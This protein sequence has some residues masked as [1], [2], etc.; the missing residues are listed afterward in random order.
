MPICAGHSGQSRSQD[1][2][3]L[4][5]RSLRRSPFL[6]PM[7]L[8]DQAQQPQPPPSPPSP[9]ASKPARSIGMGSKD[10]DG[11]LGV[12]WVPDERD[13]TMTLA[14]SQMSRLLPLSILGRP[15]DWLG[16]G[17]SLFHGL[18]WIDR[19][20]AWFFDWVLGYS[21]SGGTALKIFGGLSAVNSCKDCRNSESGELHL[22]DRFWF[23]IEETLRFVQNVCC[24]GAIL[25]GVVN[26]LVMASNH[27]GIGFT[28]VDTDKLKIELG[29]MSGMVCLMLH[30][31]LRSLI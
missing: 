26:M 20:L 16:L 21:T 12:E 17:A 31:L 15:V 13:V 27:H 8:Q 1:P 18:E 3:R 25:S 28:I 24:L 19:V 30:C 11:V 29:I 22:F 4:Q 10:R 14:W 9:L 7:L 23:K 2:R 5:A 6:L